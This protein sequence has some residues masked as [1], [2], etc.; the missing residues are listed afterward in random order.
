MA[1]RRRDGPRK[2]GPQTESAK[3]KGGNTHTSAPRV[4]TTCSAC[5]TDMISRARVGDLD[6]MYA[7]MNGDNH[8]QTYSERPTWERNLH[9][10]G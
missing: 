7:V 3:P 9:T 5:S 10:S 8:A 1:Q 6:A 2:K 4:G